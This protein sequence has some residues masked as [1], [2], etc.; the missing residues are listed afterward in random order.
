MT[1]DTLLQI[2]AL[3][4]AWVMAIYAV[5]TFW[6]SF[7]RAGLR[8][9][10]LRL[11]S[12]RVLLPALAVVSLYLLSLALVFVLPEQIAVVLSIISPGGLRPQP[13]RAGLHVIFPVLERAVRYTISWQTYTMAALPAEGGSLGDD[14][15]RARSSDGQEVRLDSS[16][17][18]RIDQDQILAIHIDW[19]NRYIEDLIRPVMRG[20]VRTQASQFTLR[21]INSDK[22]K[23][24]EL[25]LDRTFR[26]HFAEKGFIVDQFLLRDITFVPEY[27]ASIEQKQIALEGEE[28]KKHEAQQLRNLAQGRADSTRIEAQ[29][30]AE[31]IKLIGEA[32]KDNPNVLTQLYIDKLSPNIR[33]MLLPNNAP[34]LLPLP[35]F[36]EQ[37]RTAVPT[38]L[39]GP[40]GSTPAAP[41]PR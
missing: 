40:A 36:E 17:I 5:I 22:R 20:Q 24:L 33:I 12:F 41:P 10:I 4:A 25:T 3:I 21:E 35:H 11:F 19:Q 2:I 18:F 13:L 38:L 37:E 39:P 14:S 26:E 28:Q 15:I 9:A 30:Q 31:S 27:A 7:R 16:L 34:L 32:L 8:F 29:A 23:D 6:V 1:L